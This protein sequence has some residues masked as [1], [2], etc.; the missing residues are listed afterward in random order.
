MPRTLEHYLWRCNYNAG[1]KAHDGCVRLGRSKRWKRLLRRSNAFD[2]SERADDRTYLKDR[3][4]WQCQVERK[5]TLSMLLTSKLNAPDIAATTATLYHWV[6][7]SSIRV[8]TKFYGANC[9]NISI[10]TVFDC[11][12]HI[13]RQTGKCTA[14]YTL[15]AP[16]GYYKRNRNINNLFI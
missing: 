15:F 1:C 2:W 5:V 10:V 11:L 8:I 13:H 12:H 14:R 4:R 9:S 3:K 6:I 7:T 16:I